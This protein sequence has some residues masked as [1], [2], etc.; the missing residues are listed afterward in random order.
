MCKIRCMAEMYPRCVW[1][2]ALQSLSAFSAPGR[3][4]RCP[5]L[6]RTRGGGAAAAR[7][8]L[9]LCWVCAGPLVVI[10]KVAGA[11]PSRCVPALPP[12]AV[13]SAR[14]VPR[15]RLPSSRCRWYAA[16][17]VRRDLS[18]AR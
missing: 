17:I 12:G 4:G 8:A 14:P 9:C 5:W 1:S 11:A 7:T 10:S 13:C 16:A 15:R 3:I 6:P 2:G 18:A